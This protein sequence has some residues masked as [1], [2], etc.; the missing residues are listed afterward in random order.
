LQDF[1]ELGGLVMP[2]GVE[3]F[4]RDMNDRPA[5]RASG[6]HGANAATY[7]IRRPST[8]D[9]QPECL[10]IDVCDCSSLCGLASSPCC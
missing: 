1:G 3:K 6:L 4:S 10:V 5:S 9:G 7:H 8:G 2:A